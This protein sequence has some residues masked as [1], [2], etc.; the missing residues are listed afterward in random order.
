M[1]IRQLSANI[2][3]PATEIWRL[4]T[5]IWSLARNIYSLRIGIWFRTPTR[6]WGSHAE[7]EIPL[8]GKARNS[9]FEIRNNIETPTT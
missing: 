4:P 8:D 1:N 3:S 5:E 2:W 6:V 7:E 9:N